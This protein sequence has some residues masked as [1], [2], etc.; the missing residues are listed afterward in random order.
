MPPI[1]AILRHLPAASGEIYVEFE[2]KPGRLAL[3]D[4]ACDLIWTGEDL[5]VIGPM[6]RGLVVNGG[7][8]SMSLL[9]LDIR[10]VA[11]FLGV[12]PGELT[13]LQIPIQDIAPAFAAPLEDLFAMGGAAVLVG[14]PAPAADAH[15]ARIHAA[16]S[17]AAGA[18]PR[19]AVQEV[20]WTSRHFRR[21]FQEAFGMS[22]GEFRRVARFRRAVRAMRAGRSLAEAAL[23]GGYADQPH[24]NRECRELMGMTPRAVLAGLDG[25]D[26]AEGFSV[27]HRGDAD[28][29]V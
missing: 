21:R 6:R 26:A 4:I 13:D 18:P 29:A 10:R 12:P 9:T 27:G 8:A 17:L 23:Q 16:A 22:P 25:A 19:R 28:A 2:F 14:R 15:P 3:P 7:W 24:F 11:T 1:N 5:R 20:A